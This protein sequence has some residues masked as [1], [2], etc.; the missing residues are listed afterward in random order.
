MPLVAVRR[1]AEGAPAGL[2]IVGFE[3]TV[4]CKVNL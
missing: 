4:N 1:D 2:D 3:L